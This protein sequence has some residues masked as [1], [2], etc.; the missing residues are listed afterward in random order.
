MLLQQI[1]AT[2]ERTADISVVVAGLRLV[3]RLFF[4]GK[5][6]DCLS[7]FWPSGG[8]DVACEAWR[9][10]VVGTAGAAVCAAVRCV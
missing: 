1:A 3:W 7:T 4:C 8:V 5:I 9:P 2:V 10:P 6:W